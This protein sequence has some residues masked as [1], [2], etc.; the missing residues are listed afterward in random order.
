M[1]NPNR[2]VVIACLIIC[3]IKIVNKE[4]AHKISQIRLLLL[5]FYCLARQR[6]P[7][8]TERGFLLNLWGFPFNLWGFPFDIQGPGFSRNVLLHFLHNKA[9]E[10]GN[11]T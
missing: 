5:C 10:D 9:I 1:T 11:Q 4:K 3:A 8:E 6:Q 7:I 2:G